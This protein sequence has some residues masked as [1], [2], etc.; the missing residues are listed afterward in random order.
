MYRQNNVYSVQVKLYNFTSAI[1]IYN[2]FRHFFVLDKSFLH[3]Q[4]DTNGY[5]DFLHQYNG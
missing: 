3:L 2:A 1:I 4:S 5:Y